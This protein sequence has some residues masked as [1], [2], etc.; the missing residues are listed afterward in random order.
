MIWEIISKTA[1]HRLEQCKCSY[2]DWQIG[3]T[4]YNKRL[5]EAKISY[6]PEFPEGWDAITCMDEIKKLREKAGP[7]AWTPE[8]SYLHAYMMTTEIGYGQSF[9]EAQMIVEYLDRCDEG[10]PDWKENLLANDFE[11]QHEFDNANGHY[12]IY[13]HSKKI[14]LGFTVSTYSVHSTYDGKNG[15]ENIMRLS[16]VKEKANHELPD[17]AHRYTE[18]VGDYRKIAV[19]VGIDIMNRRIERGGLFKKPLLAVDFKDDTDDD[20]VYEALTA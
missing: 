9:E 11:F 12:A 17:V 3:Q 16:G 5:S 2:G 13:R 6:R 20:I 14:N 7:D 8:M 4:V 10:L 15:W 18:Y 1:D 19:A